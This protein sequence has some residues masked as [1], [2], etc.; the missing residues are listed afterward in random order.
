M[1]ADLY[2]APPDPAARAIIEVNYMTLNAYAGGVGKLL[3]VQ[4]VSGLW[5]IALAVT[6]WRRGSSAKEARKHAA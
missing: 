5:L 2:V 6:F 4:L 1:L 3:G